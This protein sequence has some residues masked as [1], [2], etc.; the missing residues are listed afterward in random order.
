MIPLFIINNS[1]QI[2]LKFSIFDLI[3]KNISQTSTISLTFK[4]R[5][6]ESYHKRMNFLSNN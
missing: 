3:L 6:A 5:Y 4:N 2:V 1:N